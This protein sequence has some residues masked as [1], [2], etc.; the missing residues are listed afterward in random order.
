M[1]KDSATRT[2]VDSKADQIKAILYLLQT[3]IE[4]FQTEVNRAYELLKIGE[5][6]K[7]SQKLNV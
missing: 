2:Q 5:R 3:N 1:A 4:E 6:T 7:L